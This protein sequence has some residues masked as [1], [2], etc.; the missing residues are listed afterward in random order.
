MSPIELKSRVGPDGVLTLSV[1]VGQAEANQ[2]VK[3]TVEPLEQAAA[4]PGLEPE[5]WVQFVDETAG[6]WEGDP[7]VRPEQGEFEVRGEWT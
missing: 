5:K 2:E 1:S 3:I 4:K 7:L 6:R